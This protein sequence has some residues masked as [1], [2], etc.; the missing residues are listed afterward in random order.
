MTI[1]LG[2]R[3]SQT[4]GYRGRVLFAIAALGLFGSLEY[5]FV[6]KIYQQMAGRRALRA[7]RDD[8]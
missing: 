5:V 7:E 3:S 1:D 8:H 6:Y 2:H 4:L